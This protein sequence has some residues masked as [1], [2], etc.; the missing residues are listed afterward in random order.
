MEELRNLEQMCSL[1][2]GRFNQYDGKD[3]ILP[4]VFKEQV[5]KI[6]SNTITYNEYSA[7]IETRGNQNG[8]L[9]IFLP[10]QWFYIASYF[11]EFYN[12][13]LRYKKEALKIVSKERLL[14]T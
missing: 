8:V 9:N 14:L 12:E 7:V 4:K 1:A 3:F 2:A 13:L 6:Y 11:T 10:N 5:T